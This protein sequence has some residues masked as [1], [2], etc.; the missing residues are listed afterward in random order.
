MICEKFME[1]NWSHDLSKK[2]LKSTSLECWFWIVGSVDGFDLIWYH[3]P[4]RICPHDIDMKIVWL[5]GAFKTKN[6][7]QIAGILWHKTSKPTNHYISKTAIYDYRHTL[8]R[9][10][11]CLCTPDIVMSQG[12]YTCS[13]WGLVCK[14]SPEW[15]N[16]HRKVRG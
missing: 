2:D 7:S 12:W 14:W 5:H 9:S 16:L 10:N 13:S 6:I 15:E 11:L 1:Q 3:S 4:N 8:L